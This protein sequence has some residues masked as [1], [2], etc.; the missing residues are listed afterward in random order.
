MRDAMPWSV[1]VQQYY[2]ISIHASHARC[3]DNDRSEF[4]S[5]FDFNSRISCEMRLIKLMNTLK[6][7]AISIHA[8]HARCDGQLKLERLKDGISIHA[9]HARCDV[10][11]T[12]P[13]QSSTDFN[14]RISCEMRFFYTSLNLLFW[15]FNSRISCEMRSI[16]ASVDIPKQ[17]F[18]SRIS[19]EMR[20]IHLEKHD[21]LLW[22]QFTHL[23][24]DAMINLLA[25]TGTLF[26]SIHAS[27]A[28]CDW[29]R[30]NDTLRSRY[31]NSRI[32][33]EM[34]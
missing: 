27:H 4:H 22:F 16:G 20:L 26:I 11:P 19:C 24:R 9:S 34:R 18:N 28:R 7:Q 15:Y 5:Q 17:N 32:S 2:R 14:S 6:P 31:F 13:S 23:M 25:P 33:C 12:V 8:S 29:V 3:D 30:W 21:S 1:L 10:A